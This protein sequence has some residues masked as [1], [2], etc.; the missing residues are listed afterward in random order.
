[1]PLAEIAVLVLEYFVIHGDHLTEHLAL[2]LLH[3]ISHRISINKTPFLGIMCMQVK[4]KT[5]S[6]LLVEVR[7]Q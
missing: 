2:D 4:V 6:A 3:E 7:G 5:Q 1:M